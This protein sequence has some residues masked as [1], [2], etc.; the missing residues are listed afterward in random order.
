MFD[1][2]NNYFAKVWL[3]FILQILKLGL[4]KVE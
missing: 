3:V 2:S 4:I 1:I